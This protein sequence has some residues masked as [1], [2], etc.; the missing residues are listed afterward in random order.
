L[1]SDL[2]L[3][4]RITA[5]GNLL[6][7]SQHLSVTQK[8]HI[9][10]TV[11]TATALLIVGFALLVFEA[12]SLHAAD[13]RELHEDTRLIAGNCAAAVELGEVDAIREALLF[14]RNFAKVRSAALYDTKGQI[15]AS[16]QTPG[17]LFD[18]PAQQ[19]RAGS[20]FRAFHLG[21]AQSVLRNGNAVG[22]IYVNGDLS[23]LKDRIVLI[24]AAL[25]LS[26]PAALV[27]ITPVLRRMSNRI[28]RPLRELAWTTKIVTLQ[29][30][31]SV[32]AKK[33]S[34]DEVGHLVDAFNEML[35]QIENQT[36]DL[37]RSHGN[38]ELRVAERTHELEQE[39]AER[40]Q[41]E[42]AL[43]RAK[44]LADRA[45]R[46]KSEFLANMSHEIRTPLNG[47]IGLTELA[48][49][50]ETSEEIHGDLQ[51][52]K[53]S[54]L[55]LLE[56]INDILDFSKV[57]AGRLDI[58]SEPFSLRSTLSETVQALAL[59]ARKK[60]LRLI[61]EIP[62]EIPDN[63]T[64]D[65]TRIRQV[66]MNLIG[67]AIKFTDAGDVR[68]EVSASQ[69]MAEAIE[70]HF[71]VRDT[72]IGVSS[73]AQRKIFE[74]FIQAD[75]SSTRKQGGT[76][77]GLTISKRLVE[78]M[79]GRLWLESEVSVG[80]AFHFTLQ[81]GRGDAMETIATQPSLEARGIQ[82]NEF[83]DA[84]GRLKI[85][86]VE[87]NAVNR[88][89]A[90]AL[91]ERRGHIVDIAENGLRAVEAISKS[92]PNAYDLVLMDVQMP[93]MDGIEA[94]KR[95]RDLEREIQGRHQAIVAMTAHA[96]KGDRERCLAA[97]MDGYISKPVRL[98][99][100][101]AEIGRV[102][103]LCGQVSPNVRSDSP[104][105]AE[106][107]TQRL[108]AE[109]FDVNALRE[110]VQDNAELMGELVRI[111]ID[112]VPSRIREMQSAFANHD[113]AALE[114]AA[115]TLKGSAGVMSGKRLLEAARELEA[116]ARSG[117]H[118][119]A[120]DLIANVTAE[121]EILKKRIEIH[122][123]EVEA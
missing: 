123:C 85:L 95:I 109:V 66:L 29:H 63:F 108:E 116:V 62:G 2:P 1:A 33:E 24:A 100:L 70:L 54:G 75:G 56:I 27:I 87:D 107:A 121:W 55:G 114:R 61:T 32:R 90:L 47:I 8:L 15:L 38:L 101:L 84:F 7:P 106:P 4:S 20:L 98:Q 49:E 86:V 69:L 44:E 112:D 45:N 46:A 23:S 115:H 117:R 113:W 94:T 110:R 76:G 21:E 79:N 30:D 72:G 14:A 25:C 68:V 67:N 22:T 48:L 34:A 5:E 105:E 71:I 50:Q 64:G 120:P 92:Q 78:L 6:R 10:V 74:P 3:L 39:I 52:V 82:N 103:K 31:Y 96:I 65:A 37:R 83:N 11:A 60:N 99:G 77:L 93:E 19:S 119:S 104:I 42:A 89:V 118:D 57:E 35:Q 58:D 73:E 18:P 88:K 17:A 59:K 81:C 80:S 122:R 16:Y 51:T 43:Q 28:S 102:M 97:G 12:Y 40:K 13:R 111:F 53:E 41:A 26:L 9:A 91:L 36:E